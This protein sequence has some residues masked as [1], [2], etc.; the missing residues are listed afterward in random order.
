MVHWSLT[1]VDDSYLGISIFQAKVKAKKDK[2]N[3][4]KEG[5]SG[6]SKAD[7]LHGRRR[8]GRPPKYKPRGKE[9]L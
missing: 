9:V 7:N 3:A 8:R 5:K 1:S 4:L 6:H 2:K